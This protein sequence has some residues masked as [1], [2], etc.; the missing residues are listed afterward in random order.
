M[1]SYSDHTR[2]NLSISK[3]AWGIIALFAILL[4]A[5]SSCQNRP[6]AMNPSPPDLSK[7]TRVEIQI[8][9]S[10]LLFLCPSAMNY[11]INNIMNP[12][13]TEFLK[14]MDTIIVDDK[15]LIK[16]LAHDMR[17]LTYEGPVRGYIPIKDRIQF[18]CYRN[19]DRI[20]SFTLIGDIIETEDGHRFEHRGLRIFEFII[21]TTKQQIQPFILRIEC[22]NNLH[23]LYDR[24]HPYIR[25][26][27]L[28]PQ[29]SEWCDSI[30]KLN[31]T[32]EI[33]IGYTEEEL[34]GP[35]RCNSAGEGKCHY[36][37]NPNCFPK[38]PPDTVLLFE[39]KAGWNQHG[40]PELFTFDNHDPRGGCVL[41]N[42]GTVKFIRTPEELQQLRWK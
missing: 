9:P 3:A 25:K 38:S 35:L 6:E 29:A 7:C 32:D 31:K 12:D 17:L 8:K 34:I 40:G 2:K 16:E 36:A 33:Y 4:F 26:V 14:S 39:T 21:K 10:M 18:I 1:S 23:N 42:D 20:T 28:Y 19:E 37:M 30:L 13:E 27:I 11:K 24:I 5:M 41:L 15:K 22:A